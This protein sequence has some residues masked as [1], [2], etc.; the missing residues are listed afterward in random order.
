MIFSRYPFES[1][2]KNDRTMFLFKLSSG[3]GNGLHHQ[4]EESQPLLRGSSEL[5]ARFAGTRFFPKI[6]L[7]PSWRRRRRIL[8]QES[9]RGKHVFECVFFLKMLWRVYISLSKS[10]CHMRFMHCI[11]FLKRFGQ[12]A[13]DF[14]NAPQCRKRMWQLDF[15]TICE[16]I[17]GLLVH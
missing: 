3:L 11:T 12:P 13:K 16:I 8:V 1:L 15:D 4:V 2:H 17:H 9:E 14:Q 5:P 10:S 6:L 7:G